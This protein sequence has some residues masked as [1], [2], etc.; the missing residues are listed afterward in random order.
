[1][2]P[3]PKVTK[4]QILQCALTLVRKK[5]VGALTAKRLA[6]ELSCS[7]QPIFWHYESMESLKQDIF[8]A[9]LAIFGE[10]LRRHDPKHSPYLTIGLNYIR[11]ATEERELFRLLFMS[12]FGHTDVID[13]RVEM[14]YILGIIEESEDVRQETAQII[15]RD[16][17]LFSHG[18]AAMMATGTANF[19]EE[20]VQDMLSD[21][22]RGLL[23]NLRNKK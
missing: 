19:N 4:E 3:K 10:H 20:E 23:T 12:D 17:W 14:D 8:D 7:T 16:M 2:P 6:T 18:I 5:G 13:A 11:F 21:V 9:A 22:Y 15:Y 1:M